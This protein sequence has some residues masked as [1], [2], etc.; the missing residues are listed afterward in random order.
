MSNKVVVS[1]ICVVIVLMVVQLWITIVGVNSRLVKLNRRIVSLEIELES[2]VK[3][4]TELMSDIKKVK[5]AIGEVNNGDWWS[6]DNTKGGSVVGKLD[7]ISA[8]IK[9]LKYSI[10]AMKR[11]SKAT[12]GN[13][14]RETNWS[15]DLDRR[16][17][18]GLL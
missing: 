15:D 12:S 4:P 14:V 2:R 5:R 7:E 16:F 9:S 11:D 10:D 18:A 1:G 17:R 3:P 13:R 6:N 8:S